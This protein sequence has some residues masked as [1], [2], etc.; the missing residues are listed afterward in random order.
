MKPFPYYDWIRLIGVPVEIRK[1]SR[2]V[3]AGVVDDA[4]TR[5]AAL[6][7]AADAAGGRTLFTADEGY[8][9]WIKPQELAGKL[10]YKMAAAQL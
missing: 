4:M 1:D 9:A 3:R 2:V 8:E 5:P 6:W 10:C 7:L